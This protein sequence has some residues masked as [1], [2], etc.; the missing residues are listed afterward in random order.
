M[1]V[2][3]QAGTVSYRDPCVELEFGAMGKGHAVDRIVRLLVAA[4]V[5]SALV[6]FGSTLYALGSPPG[7]NAWRVGIRHPRN[8][9][10]VLEVVGLRDRAVATSGDDQQGVVIRGRRYGH[11]LD[12][13]TG[14]PAQRAA[15]ASVVA[16]TALQADALS[17]AAF[18]LGPGDGVDLLERLGLDGVI[19]TEDARG[20][21]V[22]A[23][24]CGWGRSPRGR[25]ARTPSPGVVCSSVWSRRS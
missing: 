17:T 7:E 3:P 5:A 11:I 13:R 20:R 19:A 25:L 24:T 14:R 21:V 18:V 10:R 1:A 16:P 15:S 8:P 12:P 6:D 2:D 22:A 23:H 4:G 9:N